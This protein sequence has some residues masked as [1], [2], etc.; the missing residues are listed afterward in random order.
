MK[1]KKESR[2]VESKGVERLKE[3]FDFQALSH[4]CTNCSVIFN[5]L[6]KITLS[7]EIEASERHTKPSERGGIVKR[8]GMKVEAV[9]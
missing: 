6:Q 8:G 9:L 4:A 2:E 7:L 3:S 5:P 1:R